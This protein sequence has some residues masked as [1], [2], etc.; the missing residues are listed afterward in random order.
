[1]TTLTK[2]FHQFATLNKPNQILTLNKKITLTVYTQGSHHWKFRKFLKNQ[3]IT[4]LF[5]T[6]GFN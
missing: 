2:V 5:K 3:F 6:I 4:S 1:M